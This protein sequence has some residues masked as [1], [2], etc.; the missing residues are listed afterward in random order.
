MAKILAVLYDDRVDGYPTGTVRDDLPAIFRL[1]R[2]PDDAQPQRHRFPT[3]RSCSA[4]SPASSGL[5]NFLE[6]AGHAGR[7]LRQ[8][9]PGL[10]L[11][12]RAGR[13]R[14]RH[15]AAL[16]AGLSDRRA[17][18]QGDEA[19][20]RAHRRYRLG[21]CRPAG[22]DR[23]RHHR[24]RGHLLQ[25]DQRRRACRD[26]DP[27]PGAQ[28]P[29]VARLG[30]RGGWNIADCATRS[31]DLEGMH[32][33]TVA[34]GRI[35]LAVLRR[36]KP[37]DVHLH[38]YDRHRLPPRSRRSSA[39]PSTASVEDMVGLRRGHDHLSRSIRRPRTCSTRR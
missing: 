14:R 18:R 16:L 22:G 6:A 29:P 38:Y 36:L 13:C 25:L 8:G 20:A 15:L 21:P 4:A 9:R 1:S 10:G 19:Q 39:S 12:A 28:L 30:A 31:Y 24:R 37:F 11:R 7:D 33:G 32:V 27:G 17:H 3:G 26:D 35:G 23:P 34:A 5:R 2:R